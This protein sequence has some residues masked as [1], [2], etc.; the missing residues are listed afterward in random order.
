MGMK[1]RKTFVYFWQQHEAGYWLKLC[2]EE[3]RHLLNLRCKKRYSA[4][5]MPIVDD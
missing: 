3:K 5:K 4:L 2:E 1:H